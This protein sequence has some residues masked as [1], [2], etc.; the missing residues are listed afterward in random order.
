MRTGKENISLEQKL[1]NIKNIIY[2]KIQ[3]VWMA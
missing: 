2:E 1:G 3:I